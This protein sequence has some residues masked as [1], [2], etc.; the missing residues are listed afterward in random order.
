MFH[1][2]IQLPPKP[3]QSMFL[4]GA[5][6]TGKSTLLRT[7]YA[8]ALWVNLIETDTWAS[9]VREPW[10]LRMQIRSQ[11][12]KPS[13]VVIDEIQ[14]V[15]ALLDEV[16]LMIEEDKMVFVL[17]GS[18]ARKVRRGHANLLGGRAIRHELYG[19][20]IGE[21]GA[22]YD[23]TH[24]LNVGSLPRHI[25]AEDAAP[26]L[27]SYVN[28]Y[29]R[30]EIAAEGLVRDIPIFANALTAIALSD[31]TPINYSNIAREC[32]VASQTVRDY[33]QILEDTLIGTLL[34]AYT[35]KPK[36]RIIRSPKFYFFDVGVTNVLC[37]RRRI[38]QGSEAYG[39]ALENWMH[40]ELRAHREYADLHYDLSYW[41]LSG[42]LEVDFILGDMEVALEVKSAE[43]I[44]DH[45][46]RGLRAV[47]QDYP[48][49]KPIL[50][51]TERSAR[52][53]DDGI[54]ILPVE[55]FLA[56]LWAG[57]IVR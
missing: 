52:K 26:L 30:E 5:R 22:A 40:H 11:P 10:Q 7:L 25:L 37:K 54:S 4:W 57:K 29:L 51:C 38:E 21:V 31:G 15:P 1:R 9:Y 47:K 28:E 14:K 12:T 55:Q 18:S 17:S 34:P 13:L 53:T 43:H 35:R 41:Q 42:G 39:K 46:L 20:T 27:R 56:E 3:K 50:V 49:V 6:Q 16:H 23:L 36:R 19:L 24:L 44:A 8:D 33:V 48:S 32:A 45:H 2:S